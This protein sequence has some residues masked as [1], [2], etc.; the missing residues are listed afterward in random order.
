MRKARLR[1]R[2]SV[3]GAGPGQNLKFSLARITSAFA[4]MPVWSKSLKP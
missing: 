1:A 4:S 2:L 3:T